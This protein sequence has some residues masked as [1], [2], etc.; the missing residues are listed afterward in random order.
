MAVSIPVFVMI[1]AKRPAASTV[2]TI[3]IAALP[4]AVSR[5]CCSRADGKLTTSAM[6]QAIRKTTGSG[7]EFDHERRQCAASVSTG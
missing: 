3:T 5:S 1:P 2:V 4:C 7:S 6:A